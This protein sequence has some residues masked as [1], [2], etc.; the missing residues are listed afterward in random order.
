MEVW[1]DTEKHYGDMPSVKPFPGQ[2]NMNKKPAART[3][4][5]RIWAAFFYSL[6]GLWYAVRNESAFRQELC[7]FV[8]LLVILVF[9]PISTTFKSMLFF[10]NSIVLVVEL[11][12]SAIESVVDLSSP[13]YNILA[14][15]AKDLGS[16][17]VF[18]SLVL[19]IVLWLVALFH[20]IYGGGLQANIF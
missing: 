5:A 1:S 13:E 4:F 15:R 9:L 19:A 3:G 6:H 14:K 10:A 2:N 20:I 16:A 18:V 11:L 12:N 17:A 7:L 8:V